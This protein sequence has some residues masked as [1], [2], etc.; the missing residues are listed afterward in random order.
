MRSDQRRQSLPR[1][2]RV[3]LRQGQCPPRLLLVHFITKTWQCGLFRHRQSSL[4]DCPN[5]PDHAKRP[6][7]FRHSRV[8]QKM[9]R[10]RDVAVTAIYQSKRYRSFVPSIKPGSIFA[11]ITISVLE[12]TSSALSQVYASRFQSL[13]NAICGMNLY[14]YASRQP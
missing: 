6:M 12:S 1:H 14:V 13:C 8:E 3:H 4:Q 2:Q 9:R 7:L 5:L 10:S 11:K